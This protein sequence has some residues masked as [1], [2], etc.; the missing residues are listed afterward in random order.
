MIWECL[1]LKNH[2]FLLVSDYWAIFHFIKKF[3]KYFPEQKSSALKQQQFCFAFWGII[4]L[5]I[6]LCFVLALALIFEPKFLQRLLSRKRKGR[7]LGTVR[8]WATPMP[9]QWEGNGRGALPYSLVYKFGQNLASWID[10]IAWLPAQPRVALHG[11][12]VCMPYSAWSEHPDSHAFGC[13]TSL[14][15]RH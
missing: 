8:G 15:L 14:V 12:S 4:F 3:S 2:Y 1:I 13:C 6:S 11:A 7:S 9:F 10:S 5:S